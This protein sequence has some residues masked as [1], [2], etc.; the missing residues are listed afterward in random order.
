[1]SAVATLPAACRATSSS[2]EYVL[3]LDVDGP[4]LQGVLQATGCGSATA[5][6]SYSPFWTSVYGQ[7]VDYPRYWIAAL[8]DS[9]ATGLGADLRWVEVTR[10]T[11]AESGN[12]IGCPWLP[13]LSICVAPPG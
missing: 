9:D 3:S 8:A 2:R 7:R 11:A 4:S 5:T 13:P 6:L 1:M 10:T 12:C